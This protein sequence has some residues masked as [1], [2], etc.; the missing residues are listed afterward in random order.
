M[1]MPDYSTNAA[2]SFG[3]VIAGALTQKLGWRAIFWF[4]VI[5]T[6]VYLVVVVFLLPE[7]QR[8]LVGNGSIP[9]RGMHRC[10]FDK[11]TKDRLVDPDEA[12]GAR[13]KR[14]HYFPNPFKCIPMLFHKGNFAIILAGS[15]TYAVKMT[16]QTSLAAQCIDVYD[17]NYLE[18][19]LVYLP[20]GIGGAIASYITGKACADRAR[21]DVQHLDCYRLISRTVS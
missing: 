3:P 15:I 21:G 9:A 20:S 12:P 4:L 1:L 5:L 6:G 18:A 14:K 2:P 11:F 10:L 7:T 17:L 19:G 8:K 16:L 13:S